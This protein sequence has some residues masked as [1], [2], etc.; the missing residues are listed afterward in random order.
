MQKQSKQ[1]KSKQIGKSLISRGLLLRE[2]IIFIILKDNKHLS[3]MRQIIK[4]V[5]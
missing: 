2:I 4:I 3:H 1:I 5:K